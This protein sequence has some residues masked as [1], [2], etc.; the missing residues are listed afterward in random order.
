[1][2][3]QDSSLASPPLA[4]A[5]D[6]ARAPATNLPAATTVL[7]GRETE[8]DATVSLVR[9]HRIATIVGAGGV[10]KTRLAIE[11]GRRLVA[12]FRHGV[13]MADLAPV[14][15]AAG[16]ATAIATALGV[17]AELAEGASSNLHDRLREFLRGRDALL[18]LDNCEHVVGF[19]AETVEDLVGRCHDLRVLDDE[20]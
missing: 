2:L 5:V 15:D 9:E 19:A 10:G 6:T 1:M 20:P 14:A 17:E 7:I 13:Y 4:P 3:A 16:V 12:E 18:I 8:I 11:V